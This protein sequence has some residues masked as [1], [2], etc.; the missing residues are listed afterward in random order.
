MK[1]GKLQSKYLEYAPIWVTKIL[2]K[3]DGYSLEKAYDIDML[4]GTLVDI[5]LKLKIREIQIALQLRQTNIY[6]T[7]FIRITQKL[8]EVD[9]KFNE[10]FDKNGIASQ[11]TIDLW[12]EKE[13]LRLQQADAAIDALKDQGVDFNDDNIDIDA[14]AKQI[15]EATKKM[16]K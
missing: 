12:Q 16:K 9:K 4:F 1:T 7:A 3:E 13:A 15:I 14:L 2:N 10:S 11:K 5:E 6:S 8:N